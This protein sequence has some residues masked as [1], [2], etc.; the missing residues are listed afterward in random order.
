[1]T[2]INGTTKTESIR[3]DSGNNTIYGGGGHDTLIGNSGN[4]HIIAVGSGG[5][6]VGFNGDD[7]IEATKRNYGQY[8]IYGGN[9]DDLI[10]MSLENRATWGPQGFH[11]YGG[12]GRDIFNFDESEKLAETLLSRIDDFQYGVDVLKIDGNIIDLFNLPK[13]MKVIEFQ[14]Q[15]WL[16]A[17]KAIIG[18]EGARIIGPGLDEPHFPALPDDILMRP[19]V[20]YENPFN[21]VPITGMHHGNLIASMPSMQ[22][23]HGGHEILSDDEQIHGTDMDDYIAAYTTS[24]VIHGMAGNDTVNAGQGRDT[25]FGDAGADQLAGGVDNDVVSGNGGND[26]LYGGGENDNVSGGGGNDR[27][28]GGPDQDRLL[29]GTGSDNILAGSG[30][31]TLYGGAGNDHCDGELG[32]DALYGGDGADTVRGGAGTDTVLGGTGADTFVFHKG[33]LAVWLKLDGST[34]DKLDQ[35]DIIRDFTIGEDRISFAGRSTPIVIDDIR[36]WATDFHGDDVYI[37]MIKS[38]GERLIIETD[39]S[40]HQIITEDNFLF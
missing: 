20:G 5:M 9:G 6:L 2:V 1:M 15:Q 35:L 10:E 13:S 29:G 30:N 21:F 18:L 8:H 14:G 34:E 17:G 36:A 25:V 7:N 37:I 12:E 24:S 33:D 27:I 32:N 11:V 22:G 19:N 40:W 38:T 26:I 16:V 3:G 4:D 23:G 28:L 31:D 39:A